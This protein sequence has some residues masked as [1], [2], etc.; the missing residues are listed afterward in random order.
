M[1]QKLD[2]IIKYKVFCLSNTC[3]NL[4]ILTA[5]LFTDINKVY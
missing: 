4:N 1:S 3:I 5:F 2:K